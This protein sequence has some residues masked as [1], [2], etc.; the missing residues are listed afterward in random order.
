MV[1][2][3]QPLSSYNI[4]LKAIHKFLQNFQ[5]PLALP[6]QA[7]KQRCLIWVGYGATFS[8]RISGRNLLN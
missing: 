1:G 6:H 7:V 5:V 8:H 3:Q 2:T 4:F